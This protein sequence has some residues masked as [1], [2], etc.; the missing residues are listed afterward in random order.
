MLGLSVDEP[1][2][3]VVSRLAAEGVQTLGPIV[4]PEHGDAVEIATPTAI[5]SFFGKPRDEERP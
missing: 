2:D 4:R 5:R 1:I 3:R